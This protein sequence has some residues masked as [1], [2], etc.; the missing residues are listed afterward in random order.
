LAQG[1][2]AEMRAL[3]FELRPPAVEEEG[4]VPALRKHVAA[5]K[6]RDG[7][8]VELRVEGE[9]RLSR[10]QERRLFRIAQE[11]LNNVVKYAQTDRAMV[12]LTMENGRVWL[13]IEDEGIG[14]DPA[15]V[16][17]GRGSMGLTSMRERAELMGGTL[18]IE[19]QPQAGTRIKVE[20]PAAQRKEEND[21]QSASRR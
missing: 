2:L 17:A 11:A 18:E 4:L 8:T 13:L 6:S 20:I 3:I 15:T 14:F 21:G 19:S 7:L 16:E 9:Q 10:D 1:A 5:L 12:T